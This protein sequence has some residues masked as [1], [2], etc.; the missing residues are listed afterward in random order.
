MK[1]LLTYSLLN[2]WKWYIEYNG[3]NP[4]GA[5][6]D[7]ENTLYKRSYDNNYMKSGKDFESKIRLCCELGYKLNDREEK[8]DCILL[9]ENDKY[10]MCIKEITDM[11]KNGVWQVPGY[12][13]ITIDNQEY[14]V[15]VKSDV[16]NGPVLYDI[17]YI[18]SQYDSTKYYQSVQHK[19]YFYCFPGIDR[20]TYIICNGKEIYLDT[21]NR[22]ETEPCTGIISDFVQWLHVFPEYEDMYHQ[23]WKAKK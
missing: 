8:N 14:V 10:D 3:N 15:Y 2:A 21:Y 11:V 4:E 7:W 20:V 18:Q 12:G 17:K 23:L 1:Y 22:D 9:L 5:K 16:L 13:D 19:L 6:S